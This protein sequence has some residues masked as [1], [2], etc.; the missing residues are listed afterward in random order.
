MVRRYD[1]LLSL[2]SMAADLVSA[3]LVFVLVSVL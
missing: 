1:T 3:I 2:V